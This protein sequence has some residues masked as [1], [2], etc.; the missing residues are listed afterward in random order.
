MAKVKETGLVMEVDCEVVEEVNEKAK[1]VLKQR[2]RELRSMKRAVKA[3]EK[4]FEELMDME[5][6]DVADMK[7]GPDF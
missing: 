5:V 6:E 7:I 4:Q 3:A 2:M 1:T